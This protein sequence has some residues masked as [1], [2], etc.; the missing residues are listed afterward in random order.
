MNKLINWMIDRSIYRLIDWLILIDETCI[1]MIDFLF[2]L[3]YLFY[4][5]ILFYFIFLIL[6]KAFTTGIH[7]N[8]QV[9]SDGVPVKNYKIID[10][11]VLYFRMAHSLW[12]DARVMV[13]SWV[14]AR[15]ENKQKCSRA[16]W[17]LYMK[18]LRALT[19]F[20]SLYFQV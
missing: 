1:Q 10:F 11:C 18:F 13:T 9:L 8:L 12:H 2:F 7:N 4:F 17:A 6:R 15:G 19:N 16:I 14:I 3:F 20:Q 5:F